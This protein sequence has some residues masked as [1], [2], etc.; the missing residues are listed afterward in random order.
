MSCSQA[1]PRSGREPPAH[2]PNCCIS[3]NTF[4]NDWLSFH[5]TATTLFDDNSCITLRMI[6]ETIRALCDGRA[7]DT[8]VGGAGQGLGAAGK[9]LYQRRPSLTLKMFRSLLSVKLEIL[10]NDRIR[11]F[12]DVEVVTSNPPWTLR[13]TLNAFRPITTPDLPTTSRTGT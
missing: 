13:S 7:R 8:R 9:R 5:E 1:L 11:L 2:S 10:Q 3:S 6:N 12:S 4:L